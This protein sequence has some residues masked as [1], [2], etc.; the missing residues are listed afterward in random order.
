MSESKLPDWMQQ[1][2]DRYLETNGAEGHLK[3]FTANGG[4]PNTPTLLLTTTGHKSGKPITL[5]LIYGRDGA[6]YIVV[7][8]KG[9]AP[10]H[11]TWYLNLAAQPKVDVQVLDKKFRAVARTAS[12]AERQRLWQL[13]AGVYPPYND[14]QKLTAREIPVVVL[15]AVR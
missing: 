15:E 6:N 14:Y 9:G 10:A 11:P 8:S 12:G 2:L 4:K 3:D 7:A 1:H 13:M 5:P